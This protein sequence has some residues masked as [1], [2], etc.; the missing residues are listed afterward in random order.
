MHQHL[1]RNVFDQYEQQE[2]RLTHALVQVLARNA[3]LAREFLCRFAEGFAPAPEEEILI[4]CQ[5]F[6]DHEGEPLTEE[7]VQQESAGRGIPDFWMY[8]R[9]AADGTEW[10][11]VCECK[12]VGSPSLGQLR[13]HIRRG[14]S[15][16]F[17]N[18]EIV[19]ITPDPIPQELFRH[20]SDVRVVSK[21]WTDV[22][23]FLRRHSHSPLVADFLDFIM[24]EYSMQALK[25]PGIPF[26]ANQRY[27]ET[28]A[29]RFLRAL[30]RELRPRLEA[31]KVLPILPISSETAKKP[32]TG[33]W[34]V[35]PFSFAASDD[36]FTKYPHIT[37]SLEPEGCGVQITL[38]NNAKSV[39]WKRVRS[40]GNQELLDTLR[41]VANDLGPRTPLERGLME[42]SLILYLEQV[43]F[44]AMRYPTR[45][46]QMSFD[47]S[48]TLGGQ[49]E[50]HIRPVGAWLPA[51]S[52]ILGAT[53]R[54][55]FELGLKVQYPYAD[56]GACRSEDFVEVLAKSAEAL[57]PFLALLAEGSQP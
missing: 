29:I 22:Y 49:P 43:H 21:T 15:Q 19:T 18:L 14:Q 48:T 41:K 34:D 9:S 4:S 13:S 31:S 8:G 30:M 44:Y 2:N 25:F 20:L 17:R 57:H 46:G 11:V 6:P 54:A 45:D 7:A 35:V 51:L 32:I 16:G 23:Q 28:A 53:T 39:Y 38:P 12:V 37:V 27:D 24:G 5:R 36:N 1:I 50:G 47:V 56:G 40:R 52:S 10:A 55:N 3:S 33:P 42:P 26:D